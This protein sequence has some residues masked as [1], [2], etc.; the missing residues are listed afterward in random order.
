MF[1]ARY[2]LTN[3]L[4]KTSSSVLVLYSLCVQV[5]ASTDV[6]QMHGLS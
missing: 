6:S 5:K 4:L 3:L 1:L 2:L